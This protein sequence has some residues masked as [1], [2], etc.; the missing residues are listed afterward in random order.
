MAP[1][2]VYS[3]N[4]PVTGSVHPARPRSPVAEPAA[5]TLLAAHVAVREP[6]PAGRTHVFDVAFVVT[7]MFMALAVLENLRADAVRRAEATRGA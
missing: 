3:M 5:A 6:C 4:T 7:M 2:A 1:V